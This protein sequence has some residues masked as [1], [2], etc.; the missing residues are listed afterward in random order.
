MKDWLKTEYGLNYAADDGALIAKK[1]DR[2]EYEGETYSRQ[3]HL[4]LD[5]HVKPNEVGRVYFAIDSKEARF[6][7]DHVGLKLYGI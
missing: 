5:D 7:V 6:I 3:Q 1:L 4:K 2:F